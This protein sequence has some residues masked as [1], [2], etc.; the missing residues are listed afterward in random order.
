MSDENE[1]PN[2]EIKYALARTPEARLAVIARHLVTRLVVPAPFL[3]DYADFADELRPYV[4]REI[5]LAQ[6][7]EAQR[8]GSFKHI[9]ELQGLLGLVDREIAN[10]PRREKGASG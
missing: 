10:R 1:S 6:I 7:A 2:L 9:L 5:L 4:R 3:P 8:S